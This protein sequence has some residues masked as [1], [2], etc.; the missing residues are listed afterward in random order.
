MEAPYNLDKV[1]SLDSSIIPEIDGKDEVSWYY[2]GVLNNEIS[3]DFPH[4]VLN[5]KSNS[6]VSLFIGEGYW[7]PR[8]VK[9]TIFYIEGVEKLETQIMFEGKKWKQ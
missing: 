9:I 4:F 6:P 3:I 5:I 1:S 7:I 2:K 8:D